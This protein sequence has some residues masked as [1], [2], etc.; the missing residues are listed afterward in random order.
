MIAMRRMKRTRHFHLHPYYEGKR[1]MCSMWSE[2]HAALFREMD[3]SN[4]EEN[5]G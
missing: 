3:Q 1:L 4:F 5:G 2:T